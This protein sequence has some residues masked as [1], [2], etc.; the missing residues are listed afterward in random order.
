MAQQRVQ[1][2]RTT[3]ALRGDLRAFGLRTS[4]L[5][6]ELVARLVERFA[7]ERTLG[8]GTPANPLPASQSTPAA[9]IDGD[10]VNTVRAPVLVDSGSA[11]HGLLGGGRGI[12]PQP[13]PPTAAQILAVNDIAE[14][15][16]LLLPAGVP[17]DRRQR[18][19]WL[20][21]QGFALRR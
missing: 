15:R 20:T 19:E 12:S 5:K 9:Y 21:Q 6:H 11:V 2:A 3:D 10:F 8:G 4:G 18:S 7:D 17:T 13:Q 16:G 14:R 1:E